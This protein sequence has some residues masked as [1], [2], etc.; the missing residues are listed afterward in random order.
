MLCLRTILT[1][2]EM[3]TRMMVKTPTSVLLVRDW[4]I[5]LDTVCMAA[6]KICETKRG[7][8]K[9]KLVMKTQGKS[10]LWNLLLFKGWSSL[11]LHAGVD[12]TDKEN[13]GKNDEDADVNSQHDQST[14][15]K[16]RTF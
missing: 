5:F 3:K 6:G 7:K 14:A 11:Y 9:D 10:S 4:T 8:E 2:A 12:G 16:H 13:V 1:K 15:E